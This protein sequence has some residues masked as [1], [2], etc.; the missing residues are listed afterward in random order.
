[1]KPEIA[2]VFMVAGISSRFGGKIK[3]F[4]IIGP[5]GESLIEYSMDQA[6]KSRFTKIIFIVGNTT[7]KPFKEKFG[8]SYKGIPIYYALQTF[9]TKLRLKPWGTSDALCSAK[10]YINCPVLVCNGDDIYGE[11]SFKTLFE[12]LKNS[13]DEATLGYK[14]IDTLPDTTPG[15]RGIFKVKD[16][17]VLELKEVLG[18]EKSNL[19]A[20][21]NKS[22]DFCSLNFYALHPKT[23][24]MLN[25][26]VEEFKKQNPNE[27]TKE[28]LLPN[29]ISELIKENKIKMKIYKATDKAY[30][31]TVPGDEEIL[32]KELEKKG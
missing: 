13:S 23:I 24:E 4:A 26:K 16:D 28:A 18:I 10:K 6:L 9:D 21:G 27:K 32:R 7:E 30:G 17:Y 15:N 1:M 19:S 25:E 14:L 20:T 29:M 2:I 8:N 11:N 5:K 3:S 12:H 31:V 22:D